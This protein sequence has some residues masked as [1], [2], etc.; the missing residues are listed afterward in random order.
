[1]SSR[2]FATQ[3]IILNRIDYGEAD[4]ILTF[5]TPDH[6][7]VGAIAK[8]VRKSQSKLA[9]GIELFSVS[10]L[11]LIAGRG[12]INTLI[13]SRLVRHYGNIVQD[14]ER[15]NLAYELLRITNKA[16]EDKPE[17]AYFE[18][19]DRGLAALNELEIDAGLTG[20]WFN[21]QLLK[22]AGHMPNLR[23]DS[24]GA[25]LSTSKSYTINMEKM[26]FDPQPKGNGSL[27]AN[28][29]KFLRLG[30]SAGRP[31]VL[32][33]VTEADQVA[34]ACGPLIQSMLKSFLRV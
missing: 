26:R 32:H 30:F 28:H 24:S 6:G 20:L 10:D 18:L 33:R 2:Q 19:L 17:A 34:S 31:Q 4:R 7:K 5:L 1:M 9:G 23:S 15:T 21:M 22:L 12:E 29:I 14:I 16:T 13:S 25:K 27:T 3:G 11:T 8:S